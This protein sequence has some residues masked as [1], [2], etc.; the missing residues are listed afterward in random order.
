MNILKMPF[1]AIYHK[2]C[3]IINNFGSSFITTSFIETVI[4]MLQFYN[5][6][7]CG[8]GK[9]SDV[10]SLQFTMDCHSIKCCKFNYLHKF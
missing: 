10:F 4:I 8:E 7:K 9:Q 1:F 6:N 3:E 2:E 5:F